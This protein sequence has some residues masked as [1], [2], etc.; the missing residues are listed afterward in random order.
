M[1]GWKSDKFGKFH[2]CWLQGWEVAKIK[3][4]NNQKFGNFQGSKISKLKVKPVNI[5]SKYFY[6]IFQNQMYFL[7]KFQIF[8]RLKIY[9]TKVLIVVIINTA[10]FW[11]YSRNGRPRYGG[12]F[13][14]GCFYFEIRSI[15]P[16]EQKSLIDY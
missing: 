3:G 12:H 14:G 1:Q 7:K 6:F 8:V 5:C 2:N 11:S 16:S 15:S 4:C 10:D 9:T 13:L